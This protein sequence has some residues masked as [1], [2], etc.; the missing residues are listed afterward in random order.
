MP[1]KRTLTMRQLRHLLCLIHGTS[2]REVCRILGLAR[3]TVQ[4]NVRR[5]AEAGLSWPLLGDL[6]DDALERLLFVRPGNK[7]GAQLRAE[8]DWASMVGEMKK[9][10]VTM[11]LL[12]EEYRA[13]HPDG[14]GYSH[15]S[16]LFRHFE[17]HLTPSM[18]QDHVAGDKVFVDY[19]GKK[20]AVVDPATGEVREAEIFVAV[21]GASDYTYAETSWPQTLPDWIGSHVRLFRFF[22]GVPRLI[23][24]DNLKA[25]VNRAS[26]YDPEIN[27]SYAMKAAHYGTAVLAALPHPEQ[28]S[29]SCLG[30]LRLYKDLDIV[31]AEAVSARALSIGALTYKSIASIVANRLG[32]AAERRRGHQ[33]VNGGV[34]PGQYSVRGDFRRTVPYSF[35][36][37]TGPEGDVAGASAASGGRRPSFPKST[38]QALTV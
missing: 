37:C 23:A 4:D 25:G 32:K 11:M 27:R 1:G 8:P 3:S 24:P 35:A 10:G 22:G 13:V 15:F 30:V 34:K 14:Y 31:T 28:G 20:L 6:T 12:W 33:P 17:S 38:G 36:L 9:P 19:S 2:T 18:R 7:T 21:L 16:D 26:F 5:V 29:R